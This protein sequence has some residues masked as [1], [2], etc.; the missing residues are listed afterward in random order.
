MRGW[1]DSGR[2]AQSAGAAPLAAST[3]RSPKQDATDNPWPSWQA[4]QDEAGAAD[5]WL[6]C[7]GWCGNS[8]FYRW[9][10]RCK[11]S[12]A[13]I[14]QQILCKQCRDLHSGICANCIVYPQET[15]RRFADATTPAIPACPLLEPTLQ[16]SPAPPHP[17]ADTGTV[18]Y[19]DPWEPQQTTPLEAPSVAPL[20][21]TELYDAWNPPPMTLA[22]R[23]PSAAAEPV[24]VPTTVAERHLA[25]S[26]T[27][28]KSPPLARPSP[29]SAQR[30]K[31][32]WPAAK[33]AA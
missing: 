20:V 30:R 6:V 1:P 33:S 29:P 13:G 14:C 32:S 23:P 18:P 16:D 4:A 9:A 12:R 24:S 21:T 10:Y 28:W 19:Q 17:P 27:P 5:P 3:P 7:G 26:S 15:L 8:F 2:F 31:W 11:F 25:D 22:D